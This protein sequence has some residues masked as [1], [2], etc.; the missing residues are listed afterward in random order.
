VEGYVKKRET[1]PE[2]IAQGKG[3]RAQGSVEEGVRGEEIAQGKG[4]RGRK[5]I[6]R[7]SKLFYL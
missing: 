2:D 7:H 1:S 6:L 3:H 4:H 5:L